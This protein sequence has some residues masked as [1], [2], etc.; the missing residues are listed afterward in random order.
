MTWTLTGRQGLAAIVAGL[1]GAVLLHVCLLLIGPALSP[2]LALTP[3]AL[4]I[5]IASTL[6]GPGAAAADPR[7]VWL[8]V[9]LHLAVSLGWAFGYVYAARS[10]G[11]LLRRP[12]ISGLLF[13]LVIYFTMLLVLVAANLFTKPTPGS[14]GFG[15]L[16]NCVFFGLPVALIVAGMAKER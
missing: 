3:A 8:G 2:A 12:V 10:L 5:F 1:A 15:L 7:F 14:V 9:G 11:Q 4:Y 6:V 16:A 13:G